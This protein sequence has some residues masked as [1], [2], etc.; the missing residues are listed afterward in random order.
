MKD[1][2]SAP[3]SRQGDRLTARFITDARKGEVTEGTYRDG[4]GLMLKVDEG[5]AARWVLRTTIKGKRRDLGLGS[6]KDVSLAAARERA[7]EIRREARQGKDP[8]ARPKAAMSFADAAKKVHAHRKHAWRNG[9]HVD[10]WI[11]TI[12]QYANPK[13][14]RKDVGE[15]ESSDVL[16]VLE[17]I[18]H[19]KAETA[20]RLRQ[21]IEVVLDWAQAKGHRHKTMANA[22]VAVRNALGNQTASRRHHE[23]LPWEVVPKFVRAVRHCRSQEGARLALEFVTLTAARTG[24]ALKATWR[25]FDLETKLWIVP[26]KRMKA[27]K[28]HRVPLSEQA[29]SLLRT[30]R[31]LWPNATVVFPG[32]YGKQ[33]SDM[34]MLM[35]MRR[36][37]MGGTPH[38]LR[39][40]FRDW[41]ADS[42]KDDGLA[43]AA[44][45]HTI[46]SKTERAYKRTDH[47]KA[48]RELMQAWADFATGKPA[49]AGEQ[50]AAEMRAQ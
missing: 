10:Q 14:G 18:W 2:N 24:E 25:E 42:G 5:G 19:T 26:A 4:K 48:R 30:A 12:K 7:D 45:A 15:I 41:C 21:R 33:L 35:C 1:S 50:P 38:G 8:T 27:K 17:P 23:A 31:E 28:E 37:G 20:R 39:S 36:L 40:S 49:K 9:K 3:R 16:A 34:A 46:G 11:N 29:V 32:R 22:A 43:E 13:I 6:V 47:F 44:L